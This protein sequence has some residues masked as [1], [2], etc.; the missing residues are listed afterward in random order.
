LVSDAV[1]KQNNTTAGSSET[2]VKEFAVKPKGLPLCVVVI[3][4]MPVANCP[5]IALKSCCSINAK[6]ANIFL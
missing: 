2:D 3:T 6:N 4:V 1:F 5:Q